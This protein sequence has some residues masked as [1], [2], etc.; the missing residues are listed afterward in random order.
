MT[1]G[2]D[3]GDD[4]VLDDARPMREGRWRARGRKGLPLDVAGG[5]IEELEAELSV[6]LDPRGAAPVGGNLTAAASSTTAMRAREEGERNERARGE[7]GA[8]RRPGRRVLLG[9]QGEQVEHGRTAAWAAAVWRQCR[10]ALWRKKT[11]FFTKTP[12]ADLKYLHPSPTA[13][14]VDLK[15]ALNQ[16]EKFH[17]NSCGLPLSFRSSTKSLRSEER[18][19]GKECLL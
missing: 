5:K 11:T 10:S 12:L 1:V 16:F 9:H 18:R 4:I 19:V 7:M 2:H 15:E 6:G 8:V 3:A 13:N 17:K 14:F